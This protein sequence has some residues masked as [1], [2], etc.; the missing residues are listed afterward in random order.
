MVDSVYANKKNDITET[1]KNLTL[2]E[3]VQDNNL[4]GWSGGSSTSGDNKIISSEFEYASIT[5][6]SKEDKSRFYYTDD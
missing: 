5:Y 6:S 4:F 1:V 3:Q 2:K